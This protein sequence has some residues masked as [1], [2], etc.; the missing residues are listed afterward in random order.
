[1][2]DPNVRRVITKFD[3][4]IAEDWQKT[5]SIEET[6]IKSVSI[7]ALSGAHSLT[8]PFIYSPALYSPIHRFTHSPIHLFTD[9]PI[10]RFTYSP[11]LKF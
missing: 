8:H 7:Q 3:I 4:E 5:E 6:G 10:H 9:S 11:A 1:M 2:S